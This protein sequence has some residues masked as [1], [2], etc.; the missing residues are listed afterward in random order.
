MSVLEWGEAFASSRGFKVPQ[1]HPVNSRQ[2]PG[3][4]HAGLYHASLSTGAWAGL[5]L[6]P[7]C[8]AKANGQVAL[9][10]LTLDIVSSTWTDR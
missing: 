7:D 4:L 2:K 3:S 8:N 6:C 10:G 1:V 9:C 5:S